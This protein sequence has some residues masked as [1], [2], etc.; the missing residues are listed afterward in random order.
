MKKISIL[1]FSVLF[2]V[3][4]T[5][6]SGLLKKNLIG[7]QYNI[8]GLG[9]YNE[10][11]ISEKLVLRSDISMNLVSIWSGIVYPETG[12]VILP[13]VSVAP[14]YYYNI[15]K[16]KDKNLNVR[17]NAANFLDVSLVYNPGWLSMSNYDVK[18]N[19]AV[20]LIPH[21]GLRRNF[22][23]NFNYEFYVG[24]GIGKSLVKG[25]DIAAIPSLGFKIGYDF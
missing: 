21:W 6:E 11:L 8:L 19:D 13:S 18:V 14:R 16:R 25:S 15:A 2:S 10:S 5:Q 24:M 7:V 9:V 22:G 1:V 20:F 23:K 4:Y 17:N 12:Y 3:F